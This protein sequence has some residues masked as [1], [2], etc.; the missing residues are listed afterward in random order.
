MKSDKLPEVSSND[1]LASLALL[2]KVLDDSIPLPFIKRRIGLD[3]ILGLV[4][5]VGD[6]IGAAVSSFIIW[7]G[8]R[9]GV[10]AHLAFKMLLNVALDS[11][12]GAI[13][14]VGD[15]FDAGWRSNTKN[16]EIIRRALDSG[17]TKGE[18]T[19]KEV[20]TL[21]L[22]LVGAALLVFLLAILFV[23]RVL[24]RLVTG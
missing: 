3:A 10:P 18:R 19:P 2:V 5:G 9:R 21:L 12:L 24:F 13:P 22:L 7:E 23:L 6:A 17:A 14:L 1:P 8:I 4:P 16:L 11:V 15:L 20:R